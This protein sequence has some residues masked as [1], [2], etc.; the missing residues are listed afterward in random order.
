MK[1]IIHATAF[2]IFSTGVLI[3]GAA[4]AG[5]SE[6]ALE[7][8]HREH[9]F[10]GD[11]AIAVSATKERL[12]ATPAATINQKIYI[13]S[14][15]I[16]DA[17]RH[18]HKDLIIPET[19]IDLIVHLENTCEPPPTSITP[20]ITTVN[21]LGVAIKRWALHSN[22]HCNLATKLETLIKQY[23]ISNSA[24]SSTLLC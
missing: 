6:L 13:R 22:C 16:I 12:I 20:E 19:Q 24:D 5:K 2:N 17:K 11:D 1:K 14:I 8:L 15:G 10:V 3:T 21:I 4:R 23:R 7:L 9:Y 18:F